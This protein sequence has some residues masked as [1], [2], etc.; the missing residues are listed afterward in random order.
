MTQQEQLT[1]KERK[2]LAAR[3]HLLDAA[4]QLV[5][6]MGTPTEFLLFCTEAINWMTYYMREMKKFE[7]KD[8]H[9][10]TAIVIIENIIPAWYAGGPDVL[11]RIADGIQEVHQYCGDEGFK[12]MINSIIVS[13]GK[14][15]EGVDWT[16]K[17]IK[18]HSLHMGVLGMIL[19]SLEQY[20]QQIHAEEML[21]AA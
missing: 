5:E 6:K 19:D 14:Y 18:K 21:K 15:S 12:D 13:H 7:M 4:N 3:H 20:G 16:S 17:G 11:E 2:V 8:D 9:H 1:A 10:Y